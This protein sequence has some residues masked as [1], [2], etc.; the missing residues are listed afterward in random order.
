MTKAS[1]EVAF[2]AFITDFSDDFS[3]SWSDETVY[4]RMDP[5]SVFQN[6]QRT[7]SVS[8]DVPASSEQEARENLIKVEKI[9]QGL[10]PIYESYNGVPVLQAA[11]LWKIKLANFITSTA[12]ASDT[13]K[14]GGLTCKLDGFTFSP[15]FGPGVFVDENGFY[16]PKN[17]KVSFSALVFHDHTVGHS[18]SNK[19]LSKYKGFPYGIPFSKSKRNIKKIANVENKM[20]APEEV[21]ESV[22]EPVVAATAAGAAGTAAAAGAA[23]A[24]TAGGVAGAAVKEVLKNQSIKEATK[25]K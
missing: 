2:K 1:Q 6:T 16:L 14:S 19:F 23:A 7:I 12:N 4:G 22:A 15:D 20:P 10:Y 9:V 21:V 25:S 11:P 18:Q 13:A 3:S 8:L 5:L 17:I 24:G